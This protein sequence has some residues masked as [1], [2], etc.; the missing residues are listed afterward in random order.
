MPILIHIKVCFAFWIPIFHQ[1]FSHSGL[2][3]TFE[4]YLHTI[5]QYCSHVWCSL[6]LPFFLFTGGFTVSSFGWLVIFRYR[7][8]VT[9]PSSIICSSIPFLLMPFWFWSFELISAFALHVTFSHSSQTLPDSHAYPVSHTN[10][11]S[12]FF[13]PSH[14]IAHSHFLFSCPLKNS[15]K[16]G[17]VNGLL[18]EYSPVFSY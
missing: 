5:L 2:S 9:D 8:T 17:L 3:L 18:R 6:R 1:T 12:I 7:S 4:A 13:S 15:S 11:L 16:T 14:K 10:R